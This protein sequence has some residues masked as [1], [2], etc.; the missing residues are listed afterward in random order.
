[1]QEDARNHAPEPATIVV[2]DDDPV[3]RL[4]C[5][6][7]LSKAGCR[8]ETFED[9]AKGLEGIAR[10]HP[11]LILVDLKMPGI[12][13]MEVIAR[14]HDT[15]PQI[16]V[17]VITGYATIGTAVEAMKS[18]AYDFLPKPFSPEELRLIVDRGIEHRTLLMESQRLEMEREL[19]KRR[20][21]TFVSHQLQSPLVAVH[22]YLEVMKTLGDSDEVVAKR[23]EWLERCLERTDEM[24][25]IIKDWLSLS[26]VESGHLCKEQ[27]RIDLK[28]IIRNILKNYEATASEKDVSVDIDMPEA[29]YYVTGDH[30]CLNML[31]DNLVAN[32]IKYNKPN[33]GVSVTGELAGDHIVVSVT[34]TG[35]GIAEETRESL[36]QEFYRAKGRVSRETTGTGL[37][38]AICKKITSELLGSIDVQSEL[39]V[40][41]T[42]RV[43]LPA[44]RDG[45]N[46][47]GK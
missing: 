14:V 34:D 20:F 12:S 6:K 31:F 8:V 35:I 39:N 19:L 37:G 42:F 10:V 22:Q 23:R 26:K 9:G 44:Y 33:G 28:P 11:D 46:N 27:V 16:I 36:F 41:S 30:S 29:A 24:L 4:S 7:I 15:D 1:M 3:M 2:V 13:G 40:G 5:S 32:A 38:L 25:A 47:A 17:I 45:G 21:V 18:G 43:H